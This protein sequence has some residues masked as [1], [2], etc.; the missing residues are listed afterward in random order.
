M[1]TADKFLIAV[2][3]RPARRPDIP[4][5]GETI[6]DSDQLLWGGV[7]S[8]PKRLIVVGAGVIG[9]EYA[10]MM[11]IIPGMEVTIVDGRREILDMADREV[12][13]ALCYS[14]RQ[15][16]ARFF[17]EETIKSVEKA[18]NG[19]VIVQ[20]NSGKTLVGDGLLYTLGRQG[21][22]EGLNLGAIGLEADKRGLIEVDDDFQ[23]AV[24]H[25]YVSFCLNMTGGERSLCK[26][27]ALIDFAIVNTQLCCRR[28]HW[29]PCAR[30]DV[31]GAG[32]PG[33][34]AHAHGQADEQEG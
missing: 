4:F 28:L 12:S 29:V 13:E 23:T 10:S 11:S 21:N 32:P 1:L 9:M 25:M 14:M 6:F 30:V 3:T 7:K 2:G 5:D 33:V 8:V 19:E 15:T 31:D 16:G 27:W 18:D 26:W 34:G 17:V 22:T 20:L 24:P